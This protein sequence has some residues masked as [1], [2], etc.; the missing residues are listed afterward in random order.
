[1][2]LCARITKTS[3]MYNYYIMKVHCLL[4]TYYTALHIQLTFNSC[5]SYTS[6]NRCWFLLFKAEVSST[7]WRKLYSSTLGFIASYSYTPTAHITR[8]TCVCLTHT[9]CAWCANYNI[10]MFT[11]IVI[12]YQGGFLWCILSTS[13][14]SWSALSTTI[15]NSSL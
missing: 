9:C 1:M 13:T 15:T 10:H 11:A 4:I 12:I 5:S 3:V 6:T 8:N 2:T 7:T 14:S